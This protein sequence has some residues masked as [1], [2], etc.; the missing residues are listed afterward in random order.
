MGKSE[1]LVRLPYLH[2]NKQ[3]SGSSTNVCLRFLLLLVMNGWIGQVK[4]GTGVNCNFFTYYLQN[5]SSIKLFKHESVIIHSVS[6][7][8]FRSQYNGTR[9]Y[10]AKN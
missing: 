3:Q 8:H 4:F 10:V 9:S 1:T 6:L 7:L 2:N 5:N